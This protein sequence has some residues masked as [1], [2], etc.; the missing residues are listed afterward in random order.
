MK[1]EDLVRENIKSLKAFSSARAEF[2][3]DAD[4]FLDA[5]ESPYQSAY[6]RY[7][8]PHQRD[9]KS[10]IA[11]TRDV[12]IEEIILGN[13]SDELIDL[14]VRTFCE[15]K[16]DVIRY[17]SP[18][19]GMYKV[20][21]DINDVIREEVALDG[22]FD[23]DVGLCLGNQT[24]YHKLL[25]LCSPNN[26]TG[27]LLSQDRVLKVVKGWQGIVV[28]DEAYIE[29]ADQDSIL[30]QLS[31]LENVIVL[32]TFSKAMGGAGLR[33]GMG[34][35]SEKII[36]YL[37][38][39]KP[40]YNV[41]NHTQAAAK[42]MLEN[43]DVIKSQILECISEREKVIETLLTQKGVEKIYP[44]DTN[45]VLV[46]FEKHKGLYQ[47]LMGRGVI[48]RDRSSQLNCTGCLRLTIGLPKE[49][50]LLLK[51]IN[52]YYEEGAIHR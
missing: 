45:F 35:A 11:D 5:N 24:T 1:L 14:I 30:T 41:N 21:A 13:G 47:Y 51:L 10:M 34:F 32:Q 46:R 31:K 36:S 19:F 4:V 38:K 43:A 9:L 39:V 40:P 44:S 23:L 25:F 42:S 3:G 50:D 29:F 16:K 49:N 12:G 26:P 18:S 8:D 52:Q 6:N 2:E 28:I 15:P 27:N 20:V 7:P 33:L 17:I 22:G 48:V 37:A